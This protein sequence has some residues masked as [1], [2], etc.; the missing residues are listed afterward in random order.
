MVENRRSKL[1]CGLDFV[2]SPNAELNSTYSGEFITDN[3]VHGK[4]LLT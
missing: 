2:R 3:P 4:I 1:S